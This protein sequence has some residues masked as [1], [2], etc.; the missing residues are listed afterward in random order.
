MGEVKVVT[1]DAV[2]GAVTGRGSLGGR[3]GGVLEYWVGERIGVAVRIVERESVERESE[4]DSVE[5][6]SDRDSVERDSDE[7]TDSGVVGGSGADGRRGCS[8]AGP[9]GE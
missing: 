4:R 7:Y 2:D 6:D 1:D 8:F 5:R 9:R 3:V